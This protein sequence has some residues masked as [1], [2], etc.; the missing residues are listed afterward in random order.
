MTRKDV[1]KVVDAL[2][3]REIGFIDMGNPTYTSVCVETG[4]T[5]VGLN[6]RNSLAVIK[7]ICEELDIED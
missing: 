1:K 3:K 5:N 7:M 2:K 6:T 4:M